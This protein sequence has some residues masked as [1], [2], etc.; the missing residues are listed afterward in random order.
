MSGSNRLSVERE[1]SDPYV[2]SR[3]GALGGRSAPGRG[4]CYPLGPGGFLHAAGAVGSG[5]GP[6]VVWIDTRTRGCERCH[7]YDVTERVAPDFYSSS[8]RRQ[9]LGDLRR[10]RSPPIDEQRIRDGSHGWEHR[11]RATDDE[12]DPIRRPEHQC[13]GSLRRGRHAGPGGEHVV[14][15]LRSRCPQRR[16]HNLGG[17]I[18]F[19]TRQGVSGVGQSAGVTTIGSTLAGSGGLIVSSES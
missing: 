5:V 12:H 3:G 8:D 7:R 11:Q 9:R 17:T 13:V 6:L 16:D 10:E 18:D 15:R 2:R 1:T 4:R 19:G 14:G